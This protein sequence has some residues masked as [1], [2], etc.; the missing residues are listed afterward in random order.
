MHSLMR[1]LALIAICSL[2]TVLL[3]CGGSGAELETEGGIRS[4][5]LAAHMQEHFIQAKAIQEAVIDGDLGGLRSAA[6]WVADHQAAEDLPE[7]WEPYVAGIR[8]AAR[9]ALEATDVST[10][11]T[12]AATIAENC[13][14]C[15][16]AVNARPLLVL[17]SE[18]PQDPATVPH[19]LGHL[20]GA[21][22]MWEGLIVPSD[23]SWANGVAPLAGD[24]LQPEH[25]PEMAEYADDVRTLAI[26]VHE[27]AAQGRDAEGQEARAAVYGEFITTCADCH[28]M[29]GIGR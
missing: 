26:R 19:M 3:A 21:D 11:A 5:A 25:L 13:G 23:V 12:A 2:L 28:A 27:L 22:R 8:S 14:S 6:Q 17:G 10:A 9:Q 18:A 1:R 7:G 24:P 4:E 20:W 29:L 16:L 15:H